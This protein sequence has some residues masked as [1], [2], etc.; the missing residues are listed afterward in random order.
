[1]KLVR[2][3]REE[4][5]LLG[6]AGEPELREC[7]DRIDRLTLRFWPFGLHSPTRTT[8]R[9]NLSLPNSEGALASAGALAVTL[10]PGLRCPSRLGYRG[11]SSR[12]FA[13]AASAS[14]TRPTAASARDSICQVC[15]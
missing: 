11:P 3:S 8:P 15:A 4:A 1:M 13:A 10:S 12:A 7:S 9:A 2:A 6:S 5:A 14:L